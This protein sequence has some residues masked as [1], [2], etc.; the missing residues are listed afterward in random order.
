MTTAARLVTCHLLRHGGTQCT[1]EA[2]DPDAARPQGRQS[3]PGRHLP[4][5]SPAADARRH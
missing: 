5:R 1:A 4:P 3:A 2:A